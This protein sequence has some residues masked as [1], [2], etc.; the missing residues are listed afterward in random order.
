MKMSRAHIYWG[1]VLGSVL[2]A[3]VAFIGSLIFEDLVGGVPHS[4]CAVLR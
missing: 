4:L 1:L 3:W 2:A